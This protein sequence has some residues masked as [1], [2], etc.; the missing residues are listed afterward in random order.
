MKT[1]RFCSQLAV[2][3]GLLTAP[4]LASAE[5]GAVHAFLR[6]PFNHPASSTLHIVPPEGGQV[7]LHRDGKAAR[8]FVAPGFV[9]VEPG[10]PY[11]VAAVRNNAIVFTSG[12]VARAGMLELV[13]TN[14]SDA[15]NV[16]YR[17]PVVANPFAVGLVPIHAVPAAALRTAMTNEAFELMLDDLQLQLNDRRRWLALGRYREGWLFNDEQVHDV[18]A[19]FNT[20][21]YQAAAARFLARRRVASP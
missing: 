15:P 16:D 4:S 8:W 18:I 10:V 5:T 2:A 14:A 17:A 19:S 3:L 11:E 7:M 20:G 13:W 12:V 1:T 9:E 21:R 6:G